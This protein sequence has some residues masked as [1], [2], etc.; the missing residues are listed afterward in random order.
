LQL[1]S[2]KVLRRLAFVP[3]AGLAVSAV[4]LSSHGRVYRLGATQTD[5]AAGFRPLSP[6]GS[7]N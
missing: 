4:A 7:A 5:I 6:D 1:L 2:H 3:V